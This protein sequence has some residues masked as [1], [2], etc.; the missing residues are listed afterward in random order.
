MANPTTP[1]TTVINFVQYTKPTSD[2]KKKNK[3]KFAPS[4]EQQPVQNAQTHISPTTT[5]S[6]KGKDKAL[7]HHLQECIDVLTQKNSKTLVFPNNPF[8]A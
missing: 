2:K 8:P 3:N 5:K 1:P 6:D 4:K 7:S